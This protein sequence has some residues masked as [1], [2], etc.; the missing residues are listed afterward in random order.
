ME[1]LTG[2]RI[3]PGVKPA[4][5]NLRRCKLVVVKGPQRGTEY[6]IAADRIRVGKAAGN[7]LVVT[8]ET[9][10]REHFE[11]V[12]DAKGYLLRDLGSTNGTFLDGAE[13]KE[14]YLRAGS[15][16]AAGA[17]ELK[18]TPFEERIE[19][20]PSERESLGEMV[21]RSLQ[22]REI[23]GLVE[24][25]APTDATV[26]IEGETGTGKDL[27]ARALHALSP[28]REQ[29]FIVVDC[30]AVSGTLIESEL[31]GHEKGA[32]TGAVSTRQGAFELAHGGTV[33]LDEMGEL[34]L[35][36]QPKLLRV[37]E[38]REFR[39]VGGSKTIQADLR[40]IAAT[41]KDLRSEVEKGKFR[42]DLYFR[43]NVVP[44]V[45]PPLRERKGDI[46][47]LV[48]HFLDKLTPAGA[49]RPALGDDTVAALTAHD[50]PG[51]IR[52]L[53][54]IIER[55]LALGR[56]PGHLV[57]PLGGALAAGGAGAGAGP[58]PELSFAPDLSF[59]EQKE[60]WVETFERRYLQWLIARAEGN[61]SKA[62]RDADMDRKYLH[63]LLKKYGIE[64]GGS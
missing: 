30:G 20:L 33:F 39:R 42:E 64:P 45:A 62:A 12:R 35:D 40:V 44:M 10:S 63:K 24:R 59:R 15:V 16:V 50:W 21:G 32:F 53:R 11:I 29:P 9:V 34:S 55:A 36:L 43:L 1:H 31:F 7:D 17:T 57:A 56:D 8:D 4:T 22:I 48:E 18:F 37:L 46:P 51:N 47:L 54:N 19:I 2:T 28:R 38:Q 14:A 41:R 26:L 6:L 61:I 60:R 27:I 23:F 58:Q 5:V 52:E 3:N 13:I 25:I 49:Q